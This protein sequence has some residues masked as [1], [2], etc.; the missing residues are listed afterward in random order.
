[1]KTQLSNIIHTM[2]VHK[3]ACGGSCEEHA[4]FYNNGSSVQ[5]EATKAGDVN[6]QEYVTFTKQI[7]AA[8]SLY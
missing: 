4:L 6:I 1:M 5:F 8:L 7:L 2:V 3:Y